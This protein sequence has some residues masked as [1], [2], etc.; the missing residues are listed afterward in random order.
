MVVLAQLSR[1]VVRSV[2]ETALRGR[3]DADFSSARTAWAGA[4]Q[5][6]MS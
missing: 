6:V 2:V 5:R 3:D 4:G 1:S